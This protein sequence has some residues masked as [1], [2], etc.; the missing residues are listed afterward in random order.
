MVAMDIALRNRFVPDCFAIAGQRA[1]LFQPVQFLSP[2]VAL[3]ALRSFICASVF[4]S[5]NFCASSWPLSAVLFGSSI[6]TCLSMRRAVMI[7][8]AYRAWPR[9]PRQP[10]FVVSLILQALQNISQPGREMD[11]L[12]GHRFPP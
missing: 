4:G 10:P 11:L 5:A 12:S 9:A 2:E 6:Y 3:V 8:T 1:G 7:S